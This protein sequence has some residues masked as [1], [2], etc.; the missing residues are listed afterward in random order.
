MLT[1]TTSTTS[2]TQLVGTTTSNLIFHVAPFG[3][4][5]PILN[6][7]ELFSTKSYLHFLTY[8]FLNKL[9]RLRANIFQM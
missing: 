2:Q 9:K 1:I 7:L 5:I 8:K 6:N 3:R 4:L